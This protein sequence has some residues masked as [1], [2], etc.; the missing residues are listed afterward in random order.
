MLSRCE[1]FSAK[2]ARQHFVQRQCIAIP[3]LIILVTVFVEMTLLILNL[4]IADTF[5]VLFLTVPRRIL[6]NFELVMKG[7][8]M[9]YY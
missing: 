5:Y 3:K 2:I 8:K 4:T 9:H 1:N 6:S 7:K